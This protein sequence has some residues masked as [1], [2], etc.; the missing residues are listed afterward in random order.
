MKDLESRK[1]NTIWEN[2]FLYN[3]R[4]NISKGTVFRHSFYGISEIRTSA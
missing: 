2:L 4:Y 1:M 3:R